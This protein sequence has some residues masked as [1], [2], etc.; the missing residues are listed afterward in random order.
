M[1]AVLEFS[2]YC[3]VKAVKFFRILP[4]FSQV[5]VITLLKIKLYEAV[6]KQIVSKR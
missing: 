6:I 3:L 5:K 4:D 2:P 1:N